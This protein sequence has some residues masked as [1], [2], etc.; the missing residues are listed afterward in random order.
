MVRREVFE[1][2]EKERAYQQDKWGNDFDEKNT[3]NDWVAYMSKY[4]GQ[5]VTMPFDVEK[6]RTQI[7]KVATIATAVLEQADYAP[8]HY[9][10]GERAG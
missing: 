5:A 4:L 9:D 8:R 6:F 10:T 1:E 2:I 3:P 7:L